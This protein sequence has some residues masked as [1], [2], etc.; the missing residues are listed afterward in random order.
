MN[1]TCVELL[2]MLKLENCKI[3]YF[4][5]FYPSFKSIFEKILKKSVSIL[6]IRS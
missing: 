4:F 6:P 1:S 2:K 3:E 5:G